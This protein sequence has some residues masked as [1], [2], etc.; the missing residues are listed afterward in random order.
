[1]KGIIHNMTLTQAKY[2]KKLKVKEEV[3]KKKKPFR[4][5]GRKKSKTVAGQYENGEKI[6]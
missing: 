3:R 2:N 6:Q 5:N 1:M 4:I